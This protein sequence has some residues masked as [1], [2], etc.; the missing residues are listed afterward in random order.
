MKIS[1]HIARL[2]GPTTLVLT[3]VAVGVLVPSIARADKTKKT[4]STS[5]ISINDLRTLS[6]LRYGMPFYGAMETSMLALGTTKQTGQP[7]ARPASTTTQGKT[8]VRE[9]D[10]VRAS[11]IVFV[12]A[13]SDV[14][15]AR[16]ELVQDESTLDLGIYNMLGK[17][18]MDVYRGS[19]RKGE[20]DYSLSIS[21]LPEG[22]YICIMQG[23]NYRRAEKFY[24][25]R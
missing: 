14:F 16:I 1:V 25:S 11:R 5:S 23:S 21:E 19:E 8:Q 2:L 12:R 24:I 18:V 17:K 15:N 6:A 9:V 3:M 7:A 4:T 20:H 10:T 13:S 22:V